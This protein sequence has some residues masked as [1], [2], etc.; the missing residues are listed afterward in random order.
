M[1]PSR[2][3]IFLLAFLVTLLFAA[4]AHCQVRW[5]GPRQT[6]TELAAVLRDCSVCLSNVA[7]WPAPMPEEPTVLVVGRPGAASWLNFP[8]PSPRIRLDGSPVWLPPTVY[9]SPFRYRMPHFDTF[10]RSEGVSNGGL[11]RPKADHLHQAR[12]WQ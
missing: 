2:T 7:K 1:R 12:R 9:G 5:D 11:W 6:P 8:A 3:L 10:P 4:T